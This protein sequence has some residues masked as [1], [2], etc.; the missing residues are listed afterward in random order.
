MDHLVFVQLT[1]NAGNI[2]TAWASAKTI[3]SFIPPNTYGTYPIPY[4][5]LACTFGT[6]WYVNSIE[7][8]GK[9]ANVEFGNKKDE[10]GYTK[11]AMKSAFSLMSLKTVR[12]AW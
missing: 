11:I 9:V 7:I 2:Q 3:K 10:S 6:S 8:T 4:H 1:G 12:V 5:G